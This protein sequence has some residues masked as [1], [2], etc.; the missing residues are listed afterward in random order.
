MTLFGRPMTARSAERR[1]GSRAPDPSAAATLRLDGECSRALEIGRNRLLVTGAMFVLAFSVIA[2]RLVDVT[3]TSAG[4]NGAT[5]S[6]KAAVL[7]VERADLVDRNGVL[8]ATSLPT[9]SLYARPHEV[10]DRAAAARWI[11]ATL[12]DLSAAEVMARLSEPRQFVYLR[13]TLTPRQEYDINALG[14]PGLYFQKSEKRL[15]PQGE[16]T[17]HAVGLT[18]LDNKG[19]SGIEK[20]QERGLT[21]RREALALSLDVRV[22]TVMR[23]ELLRS[24]DEFHAVGA[25]GLVMDVGTG[26]VLS[27]VSLPDYNPNDL[28]ASSPD[29]MFNRATLGVYEM[30]ST[31]KLFNTAAAL[32]SGSA[33]VDSR[34]DAIHPIKV[35]RF[36][37]T[38][39]HPENR[40]LTVPEILI[41]SSN[42]GSARMAEAMGTDTQRAFLTRIGLTRPSAI[43]LPEVGS[44]LVPNPWR[45]INTLT[46]AYGHGM[47]VTPLHM[48]TA[49]AALVNG[50]FYHPATL[51]RRQDGE[52]VPQ[53]RVV[54]PETSRTLCELMRLVVTRGTGGKADVAGYEVGGKT[55]TAEKNSRG[56]YHHKSLL[57]SFIAT[58][59]VSNPKYVVL[60][61]IDEPQGIKESFGYATAGWTA[62]PA[63]GR[64]V[65]QIGPLLGMPPQNAPEEAAVPRE[66]VAVN[67]ALHGGPD[68][69]LTFAEA[70]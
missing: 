39:F 11:A 61:M 51:L 30:G 17:A 62:A 29:A 13:R 37:I 28:A 36:E 22:Q 66:R 41:Y 35:S 27:L 10:V 59:P 5:R 40:W 70:Q 43:E 44:P 1:V 58:F 67:A 12:P 24:M 56:G 47:A 54:K 57:S 49:V 19:I 38:D 46:I 18:D 7:G 50:G 48:M 16:L 26:E 69:E 6:A 33:S 32:D 31:F 2:A 23:T 20:S 52:K 65:A 42:I 68:K 34:Y 45:D 63:V 55:G 64:V 3:L 15:Y 60:V 9:V 8:L 25:T 4:A 21:G 14:I 53:I